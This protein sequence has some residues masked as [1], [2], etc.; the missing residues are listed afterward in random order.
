MLAEISALAET[1]R[2]LGYRACSLMM[3]GDDARAEVSRAK[4]YSTEAAVRA[5]SLCIQVRGPQG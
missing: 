4:A 1:S 2:L 5:A 3:R